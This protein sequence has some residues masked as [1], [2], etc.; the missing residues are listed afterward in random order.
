MT[1]REIIR[2]GVAVAVAERVAIAIVNIYALRRPDT[3][4]LEYATNNVI[5]GQLFLPLVFL[6]AAWILTKGKSNS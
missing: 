5:V 1:T 3:W 2:I 6:L 4:S